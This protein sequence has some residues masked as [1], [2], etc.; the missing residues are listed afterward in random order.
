MRSITIYSD[1]GARPN[2]GHASYGMV[3]FIDGARIIGIGDYLGTRTNNYAEYQGII[4]ALSYMW[5]LLQSLESDAARARVQCTLTADSEL[6]IKQLR[7][8]YRCNDTLQPVYRE[9]KALIAKI[10][11]VTLVHVPRELN[12]L[13]DS[14]ATR[15][16][17]TKSRAR[18][19]TSIVAAE[20][21]RPVKKKRANRDGAKE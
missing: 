20:M 10:G 16:L 7:G 17:L 18:L 1:G 13:A 5:T 3:A 9:A 4:R 15:A 14:L 19:E 11:D 12:K 8:E 6:A 2:P 21:E